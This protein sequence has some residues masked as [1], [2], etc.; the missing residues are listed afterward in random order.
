MGMALPGLVAQRLGR[1]YVLID[2][3][4]EYCAMTLGRLHPGVTFVEEKPVET[5]PLFEGMT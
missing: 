3:K 1:R 5:L 2:A 4:H